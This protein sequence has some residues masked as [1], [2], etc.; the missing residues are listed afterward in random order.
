M[1]V[2][3]QCFD[4]ETIVQGLQYVPLLRSMKVTVLEAWVRARA[5]APF[6]A[7]K[8]AVG[9]ARARGP[10][11]TLL[12]QTVTSRNLICPVSFANGSFEFIEDI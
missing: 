12:K 9:G 2:L 5:R 6:W 7:L 10:I 3:V 8:T 4:E 1:Q 11:A